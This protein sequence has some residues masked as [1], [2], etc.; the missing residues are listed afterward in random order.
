MN[1]LSL[2][3]LLCQLRISPLKA[4]PPLNFLLLLLLG[5]L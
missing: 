2:S 3:R 5:S 4:R 1:F